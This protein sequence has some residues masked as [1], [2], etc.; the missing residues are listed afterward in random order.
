M[1]D[2]DDEEDSDESG[3]QL[4][5]QGAPKPQYGIPQTGQTQ[6]QKDYNEETS[7]QED[8]VDDEEEDELPSESNYKEH[9][10]KIRSSQLRDQALWAN[11][12]RDDM[13]D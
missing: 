6:H 4:S 2:P 12:R 5:I 11:Q 1:S 9:V 3:S 8:Q 10:E 13:G 7:S